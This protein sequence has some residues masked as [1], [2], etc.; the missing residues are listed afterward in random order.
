MIRDLLMAAAGTGDAPKQV[1]FMYNTSNQPTHPNK[2][3]IGTAGITNWVVPAGVTSICAIAVG[4]GGVLSTYTTSSNA[5]SGCGGGGVSFTNDIPV[6]PGETLIIDGQSHD[7][8]TEPLE[9]YLESLGVRLGFLVISTAC[10]RGYCG[11]WEIQDGR[12]YLVQFEGD[13]CPDSYAGLGVIL[14]G[15]PHCVFAHWFTG[16]LRVP[17]DKLFEYAD[18]E[19]ARDYDRDLLI[20]VERGV[21]KSKCVKHSE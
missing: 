10:W 19:C 20:E 15:F 18:G 6:T 12:L 8:R 9:E 1:V 13:L 11:T 7:M 17:Q 5:N 14:P 4:S 3:L 2:V 16:T 21:V